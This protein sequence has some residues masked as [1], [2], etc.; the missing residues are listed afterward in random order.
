MT[1]Q[2]A[3]Q[4]PQTLGSTTTITTDDDDDDISTPN[5]H[6]HHHLS[7]QSIAHC[8]SI[9][10]HTQRKP[11][12]VRYLACASFGSTHTYT[13]SRP[14]R[15][16]SS[17]VCCIGPKSWHTHSA[18]IAHD[19][20]TRVQGC[21]RFVKF[22]WKIS[23]YNLYSLDGIPFYCMCNNRFFIHDHFLT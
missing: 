17:D 7:P 3:L 20:T 19:A 10:A 4:Q 1:S 15:A 2:L 21:S 13:A 8:S 18:S 12:V 9:R 16:H 6:N 14:G 23:R 11:C 22:G 5:Q